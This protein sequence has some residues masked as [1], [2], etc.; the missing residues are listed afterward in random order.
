MKQIAV[1]M[2]SYNRVQTTL[3]SLSELFAQHLP[4]GYAFDVWL[5]DDAS[6]DGTGRKVAEAYP[7]VHVI[8]GTGSLFWC[9]GTR[10]AW[11]SAVA[12][13]KERG[14]DEYDFYLWLNDDTHL[15]QGALECLIHDYESVATEESPQH[16]IVGSFVTSPDSDFISYGTSRKP[17]GRLTPNGTPQRATGMAGNCVF[18]PKAVYHAIGPIYNG[19]H[20]A[21]GDYDYAFMMTE[22]GIPFYCASKILGWCKANHTDFTFKGKNLWQRLRLLWSPKGLCL[23]DTWVARMRHGGLLRALVS[24]AH[25]IWIAIEGKQ[26]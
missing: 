10:L 8:P 14:E 23:H 1:L 25:V 24:S 26:R 3:T 21:G 15:H 22:A 18:I 17:Y 12:Y 16:T 6:P 4:R 9:K 2:T 5:V 20:H 13:K 11:D 7:Q 19:Y